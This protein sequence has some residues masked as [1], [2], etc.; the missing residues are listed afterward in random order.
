MR[1]SIGMYK[2]IVSSVL[3]LLVNL[4]Q[5]TQPTVE[6]MVLLAYGAR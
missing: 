3:S 6:I 5:V 4:L 2:S 1:E